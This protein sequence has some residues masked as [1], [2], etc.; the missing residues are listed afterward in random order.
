MSVEGLLA[1]PVGQSPDLKGIVTRARDYPVPPGQHRHTGDETCMALEGLL[2]APVR[3]SPDLE[4]LVPSSLPLET[5]PSRSGDC[6]TGAA[7]R[8]F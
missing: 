4:G 8:P 1:G 5:R 2:A 3:Q 7:R 6:R